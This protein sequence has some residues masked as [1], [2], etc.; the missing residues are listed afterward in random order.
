MWKKIT[1]A[2]LG[3]YHKAAETIIS[4]KKDEHG[5]S[6]VVVAILLILVAVLAVVIIWAFLSDW[7]VEL[8][9]RITKSTNALAWF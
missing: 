9:E 4:F 3:A 8:W 2:F 1:N 7:L 6:G 5:L